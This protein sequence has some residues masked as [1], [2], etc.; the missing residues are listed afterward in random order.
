MATIRLLKVHHTWEDWLGIGIGLLIG[1]APWIAGQA[2]SSAVV[3]NAAL[4]GVLVLAL[5]AFEMVSLQRWEEGA[6]IACGLWLLASPFVFGYA[7]DGALRY[8]HFVLGASVVLL[9]IFELWQDWK[10]SD[11][12]LAQHGF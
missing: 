3:Y 1:L 12:E 9:A 8:W 6:E 10:L 2:D 7:A 4:V 5:A 11:S